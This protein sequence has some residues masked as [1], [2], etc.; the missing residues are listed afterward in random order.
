LHK[1]EEG[2]DIEAKEEESTKIEKQAESEGDATELIQAPVEEVKKEVSTE[3]IAKEGEAEK[4]ETK[5]EIKEP[6]QEQ[7]NT[8]EDKPSE[9]Q[10]VE[11]KKNEI[12]S[13][14]I[15]DSA[16]EDKTEEVKPESPTTAEDEVEAEINKT[17]KEIEGEEVHKETMEECEDVLQETP[18]KEEARYSLLEKLLSLLASP[19]PI[20]NVLAGYFSKVFTAILEKHKYDLLEYFLRFPEHLDNIIKHSYN[21]SIADLLG[22]MLVNDEQYDSP[23]VPEEF[24]TQKRDIITRL[25]DKLDSKNSTDGITN[26]CYILCNLVDSKQYS[27]YFLSEPVLVMLFKL[28]ESPNPISLRGVLTL[29]IILNRQK[30]YMENSSFSGV[31]SSEEGKETEMDFTNVIKCS[32]DY[33]NYAK[34]YLTEENKNDQIK[35]PY[36]QDLLPLGLDRLKVVEWILSLISFNEETI[37][38]KLLELN[39]GEVLLSLIKK[40]YMNTM[41]HQK[42]YKIFEE[43]LKT[44]MENYI[45]AVLFN[46]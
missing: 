10:K 7:T 18:K 23:S 42:V 30:S 6:P 17:E 22:K 33:L 28:A 19:E 12:E 34:K 9:E 21:K 14:K 1:G 41:L 8:T 4:T 5:E 29:M 20:N 16:S 46:L 37:V 35:T 2:V 25:I 24:G 15:E 38:N 3:P 13:K 44:N 26:C 11:I 45:E 43:A 39:M 40:Y 31:R 36:G 27:A 32:V